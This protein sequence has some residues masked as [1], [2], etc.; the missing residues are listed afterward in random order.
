MRLNQITV[1]VSDIVRSKA[2]YQ[3]LGLK[4]IVS[5][6][7]YARFLCGPDEATSATFSIHI[8]PQVRPFTGG[9]YFECNDVDAR[10]TELEALGFVFD[11][12]PTDQKWLWR[13]A[14]LSDPDGNRLCLFYAAENRIHPPW[15]V[16]AP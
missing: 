14:W 7:H 16:T 9:V 5:S 12:P 13:E 8:V 1:E 3:D 6:V 11:S 2:F 15:R 4:I 10:V